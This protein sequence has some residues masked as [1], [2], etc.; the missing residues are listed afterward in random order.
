MAGAAVIAIAIEANRQRVYKGLVPKSQE[1]AREIYKILDQI[2]WYVL[3]LPL[4]LVLGV[5]ML[6][7]ASLFLPTIPPLEYLT[8]LGD[9]WE[10]MMGIDR[11]WLMGYIL[12]PLLV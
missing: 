2:N 10:R 9:M 4:Y 7:P 8:I 11:G 3:D 12:P 1:K 6:L 5:V